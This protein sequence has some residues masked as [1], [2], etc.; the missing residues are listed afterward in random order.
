MDA[1]EEVVLAFSGGLDTSYC[2][3]SLVE[4]GYRVVTLFVDT[5][6]V[7]QEERKYVEA[8]A[9]ELGAVEHVVENG[10]QSL[11]DQMVVPMPTEKCLWTFRAA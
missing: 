9:R 8:R 1:K 6:G 5:G 7:D 3:R 11:W 4:D 2:V 10:A